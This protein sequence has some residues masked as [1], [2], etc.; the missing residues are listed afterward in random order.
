[1]KTLFA[2][3]L[4]CFVPVA[5][6]AENVRAAVVIQN[7]SADLRTTQPDRSVGRES[8]TPGLVYE[9]VGNPAGQTKLKIDATHVALAATSA[10]KIR[11]CTPAELSQAQAKFNASLN[12]D[13]RKDAKKSIA[14]NKTKAACATCPIVQAGAQK[15]FVAQTKALKEKNETLLKEAL[16]WVAA[17]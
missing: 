17:K 9:V 12:A 2:L 15:A 4:A 13:T 6:H 10:I 11:E 14:D 16:E 5:L 3:T 7:T 8:L 1:M